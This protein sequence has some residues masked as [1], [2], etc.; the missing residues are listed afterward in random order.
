VTGAER[1]PPVTIDLTR[2]DGCGICIQSCPTDVLLLDPESNR[3][4]AAFPADCCICFLCQDDCPQ[5]AI[6]IGNR[7]SNP[8]HVSIYDLLGI[9]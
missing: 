6:V 4:V 8:R 5:D 1:T 2:C 3:A 9:D 7:G